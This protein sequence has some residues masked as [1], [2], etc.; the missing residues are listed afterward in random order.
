MD[1]EKF[2]ENNIEV[3]WHNYKYPEYKQM[4]EKWKI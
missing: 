2:K 3:I 1:I 4:Y